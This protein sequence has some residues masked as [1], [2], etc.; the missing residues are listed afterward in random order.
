[1]P[2]TTYKKIITSDELT[3]QINPK[4]LKLMERFLR[5]KDTR[6]SDG[7]IKGYESDLTIFFTWVLQNCDNKFFVDI[8]KIEFAEF[9][10]YTVKILQWNSARFARM[11]SCLSSLS[12]FIERF[13]DDEY[14]TFRNVILKAVESMPKTASREKTI[15]S[16]EQIDG[17]FNYLEN[18]IKDYQV[19]CWLALAISSGARFSEILRFTT[20]IIDLEHTAFEGLFLE[21][22]RPIQTKGR[23]KH[24]KILYKYIIKDIFEERYKKWLEIREEILKENNK[25]HNSIFIKSD[26]NPATGVTV[27]TWVKKIEGFL[28]L[29]WYPHAARHYATSYLSSLGLPYNLIR[30]LFGWES[31]TMCEIYDDQTAKDKKWAELE[32]LKNHLDK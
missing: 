6:S 21:T 15:L 25:F 3:S 32:N 10:S 2:R 27:R 19:S 8:K 20:D 30:E 24:G 12:N 31:T 17:L 11:R 4:N 13:F 28:N 1:M 22:L 23:G 16:K 18:D 29:P 26:G 9:F 5:E 14:P 7:T